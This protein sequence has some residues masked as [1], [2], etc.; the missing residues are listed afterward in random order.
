MPEE[1]ILITKDKVA[2]FLEEKLERPPT[3]KEVSDFMNYLEIDI[4][5]WLRDNFKAWIQK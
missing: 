5:E 3:F 2:E 1:V 4:Y